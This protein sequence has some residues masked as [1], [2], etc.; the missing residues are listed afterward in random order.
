MHS[1]NQQKVSRRSNVIDDDEKKTNF[2]D[3]RLLRFIDA[4]CSC[5]LSGDAK[6]SKVVCAELRCGCC[7]VSVC[8]DVVW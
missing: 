1:E 3:E 7:G 2:V 4:F 8:D 6:E 5:V